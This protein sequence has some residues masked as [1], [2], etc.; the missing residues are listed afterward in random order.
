MGLYVMVILIIIF[1]PKDVNKVRIVHYTFNVVYN[2]FE[3]QTSVYHWVA[4]HG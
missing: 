4:C 2:N 3:S 1:T